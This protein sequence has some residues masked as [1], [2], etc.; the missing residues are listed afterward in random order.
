MFVTKYLMRSNLMDEHLNLV[1]SAKAEE[2]W[3]QECEVV[4]YFVSEVR[5]QREDRKG[6]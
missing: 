4:S 2:G 1:S 3:V 5:K 6:E